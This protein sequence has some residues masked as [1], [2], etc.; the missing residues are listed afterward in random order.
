MIISQEFIKEVDSFFADKALV[1]RVDK[2]MPRLAGETG[3]DIV[4]LGVE[5]DIVTVQ[6]FEEFLGTEDLGDL[7][8]LV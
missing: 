4:I 5:F 2:R 6:V 8:E 3:E 1:I 7:D